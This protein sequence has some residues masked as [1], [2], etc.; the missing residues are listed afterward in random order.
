MPSSR[1]IKRKINS[2]AKTQQITKAMKMVAAA[3]LRKVQHTAMQFRP[4][5]GKFEEIIKYLS[6]YTPPQDNKFLFLRD[7]K[8]AEIIVVASDKGLCGGFNHNIIKETEN[9]V[10][11]LSSKNI[12]VSITVVGKKVYDYF[13]FKGIQIKHFYTGILKNEAHF[14]DAKKIMN[15]A[16]KDFLEEKTDEVYIVYNKF[17]NM[18]IQR[19]TVKKVLPISFE[20]E[21]GQKQKYEKFTF[22]PS[23]EIVLEEMLLK[24]VYMS[25]YDSFLESLAGEYAARMLAMEAATKNAQDMIKK[26]TLFYNKARQAAITKELIEITTSIEAMK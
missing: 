25:L 24:Y 19:P 2:I 13:H 6:E 1:D 21:N 12:S 3:K 9:L 23:K 5:I 11:N 26:L 20:E 10:S 16:I 18:L 8:A 17:V 14:V 4:Y 22:E 7:V 15:V